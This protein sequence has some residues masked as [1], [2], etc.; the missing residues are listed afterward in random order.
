MIDPNSATSAFPAVVS[1]DP[2]DAAGE[3]REG[4]RLGLRSPARWLR[5]ACGVG[6]AHGDPRTS[7]VESASRAG[8]REHRKAVQGEA[9]SAGKDTD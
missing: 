8:G 1:H 4:R 7:G 5:D 3:R 9:A 2:G 6:G